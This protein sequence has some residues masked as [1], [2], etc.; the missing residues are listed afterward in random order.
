MSILQQIAS[1]YWTNHLKRINRVSKIRDCDL[2]R[3]IYGWSLQQR[4]WYSMILITGASGKT[5]QAVIRNLLAKGRRVRGLVRRREQTILLEQLGAQETIVCDMCDQAA[6]EAAAV[7]AKAVYHI[8]PNVHPS[9]VSIGEIA[10]HAAQSAG[11]NR[12]VYHSVL[13]PQ[14]EAMPHH[15]QKMRV[16]EKLFASGLSYTILQPAAYMQNVLANLESITNQ[17]VYAVPYALETRL[18]MVDLR[19]VAEIAARVLL[20]SGHEGATYEL[21]G[22]ELLSQNE[23][24]N[25]LGERLGR[26]VKGKVIA[27]AQWAELGRSA[28]LNDYAVETLLNMFRYYEQYGF[29]GNSHV[30]GWLIGCSPTTFSQFLDRAM[31][32]RNQ[33]AR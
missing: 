15:W 12:F 13:H 18:S 27:L 23:I 19:D 21:C 6:M 25:M 28:G 7:G 32:E 2:P 31:R 24:A 4:A 8:C 30:L 1:S 11:I 5:G 3:P 9:E 16:E 22:G 33:L 14:I 26:E 17:G 10:I 29:C 20:E